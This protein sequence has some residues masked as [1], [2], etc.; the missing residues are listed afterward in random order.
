MSIVTDEKD[1]EKKERHQ[2]E[3]LRTKPLRK[4]LRTVGVIRKRTTLFLELYNKKIN[5]LSLPIAIPLPFLFSCLWCHSLLLSVAN[6]A[7]AC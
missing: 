2:V 5:N 7:D 1:S 6:N 3:F 4:L